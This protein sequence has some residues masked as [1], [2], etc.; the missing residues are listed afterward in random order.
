AGGG[1]CTAS[2]SGNI[3]DAVNLP[4]GASTTYTATCGIAAT[5]TGTISNTATVSAPAG[6]TD[7]NPANNS[8]TDSDTVSAAPGANITGTKS[9][10][11]SFTPGSSVTY[12]IVLGNSGSGAQADN[13]GNEFIDTLPAALTYVS[14]TASS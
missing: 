10:S 5:A 1:T 14:S 12:T 9:V 7:P 8:A 11:G 3:S 13:P 6:T 4:V 2:G